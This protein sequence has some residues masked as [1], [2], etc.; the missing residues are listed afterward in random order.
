[1]S[2]ALPAGAPMAGWPEQILLAQ[3]N[4]QVAMRSAPQMNVAA[5]VNA[6]LGDGIADAATSGCYAVAETTGGV[7]IRLRTRRRTCSSLPPRTASP[8]TLRVALRTHPTRRFLQPAT[9]LA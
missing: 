9:P 5:E 2:L 4:A 8:R 1:M 7:P 6:L 3:G